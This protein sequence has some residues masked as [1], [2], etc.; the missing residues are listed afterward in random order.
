MLSRFI[1]PT[2]RT[3][4]ASSVLVLLG[5]GGLAFL[6]QTEQPAGSLVFFLLIFLH[7]LTGIA[8]AGAFGATMNALA[9]S[10]SAA[11]QGSALGVALASYAFSASAY[12]ALSN[13][14]RLTT[15]QYLAVVAGGSA[16]SFLIGAMGGV[17]I[18]SPAT[19]PSQ[20]LAANSL[21]GPSSHQFSARSTGSPD[22]YPSA[23]SAAEGVPLFN[24]S[25]FRDRLS[26]EQQ[27]PT[28]NEP[29][30]RTNRRSQEVIEMRAGPQN[31]IVH[32][33]ATHHSLHSHETILE[34]SRS[35]RSYS[36][37]LARE[38]DHEAPETHLREHNDVSDSPRPHGYRDETSNGRHSSP[39]GLSALPDHDGHGDFMEHDEYTEPLLSPPIQAGERSNNSSEHTVST[40]H[41]HSPRVGGRSLSGWALLRTLDWA[42]LFAVMVCVSGSG[43]LLINNVGAITMTLW[44]YGKKHHQSVVRSM[45]DQA[46]RS[47]VASFMVRTRDN[48]ATTTLTTRDGF[49]DKEILRVWQGRQVIAISVGN[50][51]GRL[52]MGFLAD[53]VARVSYCKASKFVLLIFPVSIFCLITQSVL[54]FGGTAWGPIRWPHVQTFRALRLISA[55]NGI[56]YGTLFGLCPTLTIDLWGLNKFSSNWGIMSLAPAF[57][58]NIFNL[59]FG[60]YVLKF[61]RCSMEAGLG[62]YRASRM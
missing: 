29:R 26:D 30:E 20:R 7:C 57:G 41:E 61:A 25:E 56:T 32:M 46:G 40:L 53:F 50:A 39:H 38:H 16:V 18:I 24:F 11:M 13:L 47:G 58:G 44:R 62:H 28:P 59:Y 35:S 23:L 36:N 4:Y 33:A 45:R 14:L 6:A 37:S 21:P 55:L 52:L 1:Y 51:V 15:T 31:G 8:N 48:V 3:L 19:Y 9:R 22:V 43:L 12:S 49:S 42:L 17:R 10:A 60:W 34:R 54:A 5:Y 2:S 27:R